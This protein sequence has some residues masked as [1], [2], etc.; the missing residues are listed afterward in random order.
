MRGKPPSRAAQEQPYA[1]QPRENDSNRRFEYRLG[2][3]RASSI[4]ERSLPP[5]F[6]RVL[7]GKE[8]SGR[9]VSCLDG[10]RLSREEYATNGRRELLGYNGVANLRFFAFFFLP[11]ARSCQTGVAR[12]LWLLRRP[13]T[14]G[15]LVPIESR[16][17]G[18]QGAI[19]SATRLNRVL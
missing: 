7:G 11:V 12:L 1:A 10:T 4:R 2:P 16:E 5:R 17:S 9:L 19:L 13:E 3:Q 8:A 18:H 14:A 6:S 15:G